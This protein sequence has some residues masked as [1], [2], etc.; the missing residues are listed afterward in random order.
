MELQKITE[1]LQMLKENSLPHS[2]TLTPSEMQLLMQ[3]FYQA[4]KEDKLPNAE[5]FLTLTN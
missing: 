5:E 1:T 3:D 2:E 4:A